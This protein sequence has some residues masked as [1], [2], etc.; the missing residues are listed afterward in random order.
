MALVV[1]GPMA[2]QISGRVGS[3]V[4]SHNKG[5]PYVRNGTIPTAS[6]TPAALA[7]KARLGGAATTWITLT[8]AQRLAWKE[9]AGENPAVNRV[10]H[11]IT[12]T[13][14]SAFVGNFARMHLASET[15]LVVPPIVSG[16]LPLLS[17]SI[18]ADLFTPGCAATFTPT[19]LGTNDAL[20]MEAVVLNSAAINHVGNLTRWIGCT[21][22]AAATD[23]DFQTDIEAV[24]GSLTEGQTIVMLA[25]VFDR[26]TGLLSTPVRASTVVVD[27]TV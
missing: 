7:A 14:I 17:F 27:T 1:P 16:P 26:V 15:T 19:P 21:A 22:K 9:W 2:G 11:Q 25:S 5:G 18:T 13:G 3:V 24:F 8:A 23:Y 20:W 10:G 4:F 6:T 12:L